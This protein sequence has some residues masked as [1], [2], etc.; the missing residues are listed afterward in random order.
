M[1]EKKWI[2]ELEEMY[3]N[4]L[5]ENEICADLSNIDFLGINIKEKSTDLPFEFKVYY[6]PDEK[7][8]IKNSD[9]QLIRF[10]F[11]NDMVKYRCVVKGTQVSRS[12]V[13]LKKNIGLK[14]FDFSNILVSLFPNMYNE[15]EN[16]SSLVEG[17]DLKYLPIHILGVKTDN[18]YRTGIN[19]EW[20]LRDYIE[21]ENNSYK[22]NDSYYC[23]YILN[24][25]SK[26]FSYLVN[27]I[28]E[29][30]GN[31]IESGKMHLWLMAI[32]Y[33]PN[34]NCIYKLYVKLDGGNLYIAKLIAKYF[35]NQYAITL[36]DSINKFL[37]LHLELKLYGFAIGIDSMGQKSINLYFISAD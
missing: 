3:S 16:I 11:N 27:F 25:K 13:V 33:F 1:D 37:K 5:K 36:A 30:Y 21:D 24:L 22:Y 32:D 35:A 29:I 17:N 28:K 14:K 31:V 20:M 34:F 6:E 18:Q 15:V 26:H 19:L 23:N 12:Y 9:H 10:A 2:D 7:P 8:I 4:I